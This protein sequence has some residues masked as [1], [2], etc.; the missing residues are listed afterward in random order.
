MKTCSKCKIEKP[1]TEFQ[2]Q[3]CKADGL[4]YNCKACRTIKAHKNYEINK[5]HILKTNYEYS[6]KR[7]KEDV[8]FRLARNLR[9][10]LNSAIKNNQKAGS[11]IKDLGCSI[12][13]LKAYI[14]SK[15]DIGMNW[16]N[17]SHT[18]WHVDHIKPLCKFLLTDEKQLKE[19]CHYTNLQPLWYNENMSKGGKY[20]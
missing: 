11:A 18:G 17:N 15:W 4:R 7:L 8:C 16:D 6:K 12:E 3:K 20:E 9:C 14:E 1:K 13:E 10:R 5:V 19:A 2:K